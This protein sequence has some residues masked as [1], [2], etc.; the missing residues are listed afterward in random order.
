MEIKRHGKSKENGDLRN[1]SELLHS[2]QGL[3]KLQIG[4]GK[5][6]KLTPPL[7]GELLAF[8]GC[9]GWVSHFVLGTWTQ[10]CTS[11]EFEAG[12]GGGS[13]WPYF[14]VYMYEI[15]K[16]NEKKRPSN[17]KMEL[18]KFFER[19]CYDE[20]LDS[21]RQFSYGFEACKY[22]PNQCTDGNEKR[23]ISLTHNCETSKTVCRHNEPL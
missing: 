8:D 16:N 7:V 14:I 13:I 4:G 3:W 18:P 10:L 19:E 21:S 1:Q 12:N 17:T 23:L 5:G 15:P 11:G 6:A 2:K 20:Y 9:K 22:A